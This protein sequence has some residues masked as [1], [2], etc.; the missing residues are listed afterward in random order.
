MTPLEVGDRV[1][2]QN[3]LGENAL[4]TEVRI[5]ELGAKTFES[6]HQLFEQSL[7]QGYTLREFTGV[8]CSRQSWAA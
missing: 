4:S 3:A 1:V 2:L 7:H 5:R 8:V 6:P